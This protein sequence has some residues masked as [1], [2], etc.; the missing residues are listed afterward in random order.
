MK[1]ILFWAITMSLSFFIG[2]AAVFLVIF[3][4]FSKPIEIGS[5]IQPSANIEVK[6]DPKCF[7]DRSF[8]GRSVTL[9]TLKIPKNGFFPKLMLDSKEWSDDFRNNWYGK[10]LKSMN[11]P[12]VAN[13]EN[14]GKEVYRFL[15][16]RTF[17]HPIAIRVER[18]NGEISLFAKEDRGAGGYEPRG[19]IKDYKR[20]ITEDEWCKF[21]SLVDESDYWR[22]GEEES[23]G[24]DGAR[25]V[26]EGVKEG[27]YH[28]V[29][30]WTP[31]S[32]KYR[33]ACLYLLKLS[34]LKVEEADLY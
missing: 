16:L 32:G 1:K 33:E 10:H 25:W 12:L 13:T 9:E 26:L 34:E 31:Q 7:S 4:Q 27:R 21:L 17:H 18:T 6:I 24:F 2:I 28:L 3:P 14:K 30:R 11:E 8:P 5:G 15:W 23:A 20:Q 19:I 22:L 29:D